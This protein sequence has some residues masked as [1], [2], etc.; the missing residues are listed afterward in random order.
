MWTGISEAYLHHKPEV[1]Q[2][3]HLEPLGETEIAE[4]LSMMPRLMGSKDVIA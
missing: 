4:R 1:R 3:F 2:Q